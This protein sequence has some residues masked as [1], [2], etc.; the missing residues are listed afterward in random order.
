MRKQSG[1]ISDENEDGS[2]S[3]LETPPR[4]RSNNWTMK[5]RTNPKSQIP[6][7]VDNKSIKNPKSESTSSEKDD[8]TVTK[9]VF[10]NT[11]SSEEDSNSF[12]LKNKDSTKNKF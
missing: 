8:S 10:E 9:L 12:N 5:L 7:T 3:F 2:S 11:S 4:P 6:F 1:Y